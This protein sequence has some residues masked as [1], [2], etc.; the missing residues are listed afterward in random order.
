MNSLIIVNYSYGTDTGHW[1]FFNPNQI[2]S[3]TV[4]VL[5]EWQYH[6]KYGVKMH[7][8]DNKPNIRLLA[9]TVTDSD[10]DGMDLEAECSLNVPCIV[11]KWRNERQKFI[12]RLKAYKCMLNLPRLAEN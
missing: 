4:R 5:R 9:L 12:A 1:V 8:Q 11:N 10:I 6:I 2:E 3:I 7:E